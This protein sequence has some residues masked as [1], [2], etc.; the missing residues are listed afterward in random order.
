M[1]GNVRSF[2][3][4][5]DKMY[6]EPCV[7]KA[8]RDAKEKGEPS[9]YVSLTDNSVCARCGA[10]S[11]LTD[12]ATVGGQALC[13]NCS[14]QVQDWPTP[15]WLK[16]GLLG[17]ALVNGRKYF[18]AGRSLYVGERLVDEGR[19]DRALPY[20]QQSLR[21][22]PESDKAVLLTA[23]VALMTGRVDIADQA[24][25]GHE[26]GHF[27]DPGQDFQEVKALWNRATMHWGRRTRRRSWKNRMATPQKQPS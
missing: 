6:C 5:K 19:F 13:P 23:K 14:Q 21:V 27:E 22:A 9:E 8:S 18:H 15:N 3:L 10:S 7:W 24:I 4:L 11:E 1:T 20:L 17:V 2:Y 16:L 12:F 25:Q 26:G